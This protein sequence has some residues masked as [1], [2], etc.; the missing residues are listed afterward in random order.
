VPALDLAAAPQTRLVA[1]VGGIKPQKNYQHAIEVFARLALA[2]DSCL[3]V[4][5]GPI[6]QEGLRCWHELR[7]AVQAHGLQERVRLRG[8]VP[9][10]ARYLGAFDRGQRFGRNG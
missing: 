5:G 2:A 9:D 3:V 4:L 8:F 6:G 10:A 7:E 1:M